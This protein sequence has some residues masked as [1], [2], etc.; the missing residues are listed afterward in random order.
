ME[1]KSANKKIPK[2]VLATAE[3]FLQDVRDVKNKLKPAKSFMMKDYLVLGKYDY[4]TCYSLFGGWSYVTELLE[5]E[6]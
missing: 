4:Y 3:E 2:T 5:K 6:K 1:E